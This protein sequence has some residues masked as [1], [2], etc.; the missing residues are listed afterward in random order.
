MRGLNIFGAMVVLAANLYVSFNHTLDLFESAGFT[1]NR[2]VVATIGAEAGF[3]VGVVNLVVARFKGIQP[4][5]PAKASGVLGLFL[6]GWSNVA[7]GWPYG[8]VGVALGLYIPAMMFATEANLGWSLSNK[9]TKED[10]QTT[11]S[12]ADQPTKTTNQDQPTAKGLV[13]RTSRPTRS[14]PAQ[15]VRPATR[16]P[17]NRAMW[18]TWPTGNRPEAKR[19]QGWSKSSRSLSRRKE[20]FRARGSLPFMQT[21]PATKLGKPS[22]NTRLV[23]PGFRPGFFCAILKVGRRWLRGW[24]QRNRAGLI[25]RPVSCKGYS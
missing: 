3:L 22:K 14:Q 8:V 4:G 7:A 9:P 15:P 6:V 21:F 5:W 2:A 16:Q 10:G 13:K 11:P 23:E 20:D 17:T 25:S 1:G 12:K 24:K 18:L 19:T